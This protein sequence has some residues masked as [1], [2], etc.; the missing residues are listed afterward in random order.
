MKP[1]RML[2]YLSK[3]PLKAK[4]ANATIRTIFRQRYKLRVLYYTIHARLGPGWGNRSQQFANAKD[5]EQ[6]SELFH[7]SH[8]IYPTR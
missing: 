5:G 1:T 6:F 2:E 3:R 8:I 7:Q 4:P